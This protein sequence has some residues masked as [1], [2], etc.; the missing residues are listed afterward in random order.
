MGARAGWALG[1][2]A[3]VRGDTAEGQRWKSRLRGKGLQ[4]RPLERFLAAMD[5]AGRN[6]LQPALAV[7]D[8][9]EMTFNGTNPPDPVARAAFHLQR[10]AW[11][12]SA[13]DSRG[14]EREWLW[15]ESSDIEGWPQGRVQA[16]EIDG[17]LG[18][19]ARFL[20]GEVLLRP[21]TEVA[22]R[23]RG[24]GYLRRVAELWRGAEPAFNVLDARAD[25]LLRRCAP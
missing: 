2:A 6:Q 3:Y 7:A 18:V 15:S 17:M 14:A 21:D 25:S 8:S 19:Y 5:L 20:R 24:C 12:A 1:L 10:G 22:D 4:A 11:L 9:L 16:G 23:T 13:G